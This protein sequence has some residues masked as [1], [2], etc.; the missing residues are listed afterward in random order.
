MKPANL[1]I[2][3]I[4]KWADEH[5]IRHGTWPTGHSGVIPGSGGESWHQVQYALRTG[6]RGRRGRTTLLR[7]LNRWRAG[8]KLMKPPSLS[9]AQI[10]RW[11]DDYYAANGRW[12]M[13]Q[14]GGIP[15]TPGETW[16]KIENALIRGDRGLPGGS[17]LARVLGQES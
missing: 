3:Q 13:R 11:A 9:V 8:R 15:G 14:S 16:R 5:F 12:P 4:V 1:E 6:K 2:Y 7:V 17:S 10:R